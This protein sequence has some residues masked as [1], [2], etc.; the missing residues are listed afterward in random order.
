VAAAVVVSAACE[1]AEPPLEAIEVASAHRACEEGELC[2]V[3]ETSC[4]SEGCGCG[5]AINEAHLLDYQKA[6][7]ECRGPRE[8]ASCESECET[9]FAKCFKGACVLTDE[10]PEIF[11]RGRSVEKVCERTRGSYVGCPECPPNA[12]CK[13]CV[14]CECPSTHRWTKKGCSAVVRTEARDIRVETRPSRATT[15]DRIKARVHNE[16]RRTIWLESQCGTPFHRAR[17][18]QDAWEKGYEPFRGKECKSGAVEIKPGDS[19]PFV[20]SNLSEFQDP[21]GEAVSP[22]T[23]RFELSYTDGT[24]SFKHHGTVYSASFDLVTEVSAR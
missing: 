9:P 21:S 15:G 4:T 18:K 24:K 2:G 11:R 22:G 5:V 3:V 19:R 10:P 23:Y 12:R 17:K 13:S 1:K 8:L 14:P 16:A 6:V 20:I 7:A